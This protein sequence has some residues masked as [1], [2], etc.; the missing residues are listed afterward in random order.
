MLC[1]HVCLS[2]TAH[3]F[4]YM[5]NRIVATTAILFFLLSLSPFCSLCLPAFLFYADCITDALC[6]VY[7][8]ASFIDVDELLNEDQRH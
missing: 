8:Q 3:R 6:L 2:F 7:E 5:E 4:A 1:V